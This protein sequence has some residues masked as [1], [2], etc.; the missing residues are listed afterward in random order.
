MTHP[1]Q[2][3]QD[4]CESIKRQEQKYAAAAEVSKISNLRV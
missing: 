2:Y 1:L 3:H 4:I